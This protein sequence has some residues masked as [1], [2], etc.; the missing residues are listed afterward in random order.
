MQAQAGTSCFL[1]VFSL[2]PTEANEIA[3]AVKAFGANCEVALTPARLREIL[4]ETACNGLLLSFPSMI[5]IDAAGKALI[6][7]LEQIY[8]TARAKWKPSESSFSV[9]ST[10]GSMA[11]T[12]PEFLSSCAVFPARRIRRNERIA[13]T[14]NVLLFSEDGYE[15][16]EQTFSLDLSAGGSLLHSTG[17]WHIGDILYLS[18]LELPWETPVKAEVRHVFPWGIPFHARSVGVRFEGMAPEH[19]E[20]LKFLLHG[21]KG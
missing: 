3:G 16:A 9:M 1:A 14:L 13:K 7:T 21:K 11:R 5:R 6:R 20:N 18:F 19:L 17:D 2:N 10:H 8:P 4:I 12:L 15:D